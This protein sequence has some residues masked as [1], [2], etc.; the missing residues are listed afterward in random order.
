MGLLDLRAAGPLAS[1][2]DSPEAATLDPTRSETGEP[3]RGLDPA[4][5]EDVRLMGSVAAGDAEAY[6]RLFDRHAP[7][8]LGLLVRMCGDRA[9]AEEV[10]QEAFLQVWQQ[11]ARYRPALASP[12]GWILM[13]ARS[14][15]LDRLR[16]SGAR[17]RSPP[18]PS[19]GRRP[20][21]PQ[22]SRPPSV[23]A[24]SARRW[25]CCPPSSGSASSWRS[26]RA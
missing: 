21:H 26:S 22:P 15:A 9:V 14:R 13:L 10:L 18:P 23:G 17:R 12:R 3:A 4:T 8:A 5:A 6:A 1:R 16:S 19:P 7:S 11:A 25:P 2:L 20:T 24:R